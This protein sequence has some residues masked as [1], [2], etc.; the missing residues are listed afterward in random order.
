MRDND[1]DIPFGDTVLNRLAK[2][3]KIRVCHRQGRV[4]GGILQLDT[5]AAATPRIGRGRPSA[6][7]RA[8]A[9]ARRRSCRNR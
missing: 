7:P 6:V 4:V 5:I 2:F 1:A 9:L 3:E 8:Q